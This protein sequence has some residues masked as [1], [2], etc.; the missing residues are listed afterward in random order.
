[1]NRNALGN[2]RDEGQF[3]G[4]GITKNRIPLTYVSNTFKP[5]GKIYHYSISAKREYGQD[6]EEDTSSPGPQS[7]LT[8]KRYPN[9][10]LDK[11]TYFIESN[12]RYKQ[13]LNR[14]KEENILPNKVFTSETYHYNKDNPYKFHPSR[15]KD[16]YKG[17]VID[18]NRNNK[19]TTEEALKKI[20]LIQRWWK[21]CL[22]RNK[23]SYER[24]SSVIKRQ[25]YTRNDHV[26]GNFG[27]KFIVQTTRVEVFKK[28][29]MSI[30]LIKPEIIS[31]ENK[32]NLSQRNNN[33][34]N[35]E[36]VLDKDS[37]KQN[38]ANIWNE[39]NIY[40]LADSL[41]IIQNDNFNKE[42]ILRG[43]N[44]KKYEEEI[45]RLKNALKLK[46]K[47]INNLSNKLKSLQNKKALFK[48]QLVDNLFINNQE[49]ITIQHNSS[50]ETNDNFEIL[51]LLREPLQ[52]QLIDN[53]F[54]LNN[55]I[56]FPTI[57]T[58]DKTISE[59]RDNLEILP[60]EKDS[61]KKQQVDNLFIEKIY[62]IKP[63]NII[64]NIDKLTISKLIK[65]QNSIES[66]ESL[67]I[68][69]SQKEPLKMQIVDALFIQKNTKPENEIQKTE[70]INLFKIKKPQN[71]HEN[72][73]S[74]EISVIDEEK[75]LQKQ[76]LDNFFVEKTI[77]TKP[78]NILQNVD[79]LTIIKNER[80]NNIIESEHSF[81]LLPKEKE[82]LK[83]QTIDSLFIERI[84]HIPSFKN[85]L[86]QGI[87]GITIKLK[88]K[89]ALSFQG[90]D[91]IFIESLEKEKNEKQQTCLMTI[92][93]IQ[94]PL[95][96]II[97]FDS[98][99]ISPRLKKPLQTQY[100]DNISFESKAIPENKIQNID[101]IQ[102]KDKNREPNIIDVT[103]SIN[104]LQ[105]EKDSLI[106]EDIDS[107]FIEQLI[108]E[109]NLIQQ[110][111]EFTIIKKEKPELLIEEK[112]S[113]LIPQKEKE[114]LDVNYIDD[115]LL[116]GKNYPINEIQNIDTINLLQKE[117]PKNE[118]SL[119]V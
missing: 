8:E 77:K 57:F 42:K 34:D 59:A 18:L 73:D 76:T 17:G 35:L 98:L 97:K 87:D 38:M 80:P 64:Q 16:G 86:I 82:N 115:L 68:Y 19:F 104:L 78:E 92:L 94:K 71:I 107:I 117:R 20:N 119:N 69:P 72:I 30:P 88:E 23:I 32:I 61:L 118:G 24:Y 52:K 37:L 44:L 21:R 22:N 93:K 84:P 36:I 55:H 45:N 81:E 40:S 85:L 90:I 65:E 105:K 70:S 112:D 96:E 39:D 47:E 28:P 113:I 53:L 108:K 109:E 67:E 111:D 10:N 25:S 13:F 2:P 46:E 11:K 51:P 106:N 95:N 79:R 74:I 63:E 89:D 3:S 54:I 14:R 9:L 66:G 6:L 99:Y 50:I 12:N 75:I 100:I 116:T 48:R 83:K 29:Y 110:I 101:K 49:N 27:N 103:N 31:K 43:I 62:L 1:M 33:E 5:E 41:S 60:I 15:E 58:E 4:K 91:T 7:N 114:I 26:N 102:L 56:Y